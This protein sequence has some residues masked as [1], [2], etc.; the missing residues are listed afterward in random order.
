MAIDGFNDGRNAMVITTNPH[1]VQRD[2]LSFD[3]T[4]IDLDWDGLWKV[5][6][7]RSDSGWYAEFAIP[8]KSLRY[9]KPTSETAEW[10]YNMNRSRRM[11]NENYALSPFPRSFNVLRM[12]YAGKLVGIKPPPLSPNIRVQPF[13]LTSFDKYQ[14]IAD[15]KPQDTQVKIGGEIN[16]H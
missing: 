14:N 4:L 11:T 12:D 2:F 13:L 3:A 8:W 1:G 5:R 16:G 10:G 6:T 9:N 7:S 15:K